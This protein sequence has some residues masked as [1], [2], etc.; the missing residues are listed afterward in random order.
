[1]SFLQDFS[2]ISS[3]RKA[4]KDLWPAY[5]AAGSFLHKSTGRISSAN[6]NLD[7]FKRKKD[8]RTGDS[9][10]ISAGGAFLKKMNFWRAG[11]AAGGALLGAQAASDAI[12]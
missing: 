11:V 8:L 10:K 6:L 3:F 2:L 7:E 5:G 1:M 9:Q 4:V 12:I